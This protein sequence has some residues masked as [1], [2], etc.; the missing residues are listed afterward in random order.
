MDDVTLA[1]AKEHLDDLIACA[2]RGEEVRI[3]DPAK[4]AWRIVPAGVVNSKPASV[5]F[6]QWKHL[7]DIS[8]DRLLAPL[9]DEDLAWFS[10]EKSAV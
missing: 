3:I 6:G 7:K 9:S 4:R 10:G 1:H 2:A 8:E 5:I